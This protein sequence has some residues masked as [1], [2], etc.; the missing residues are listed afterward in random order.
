MLKKILF[1]ILG[2]WVFIF[3]IDF[4]CIKTID[5]PIFMIKKE[6]DNN[7]VTYYGLL[8][9]AIDYDKDIEIGTYFMK[10]DSNKVLSDSERFKQE[11]SSVSDSNVFVYKSI[12]DVIDILKNGTGV[13]YLGFPECKWCQA[14]VKYLD[15]V[16]SDIEINKIY[17]CNVLEDRQNNTESYKKLVEV[18]GDNLQYDD[19][20]KKRVYVPNVS[21]VV[22]GK[23]IGNDYETSKNTLGFS[24]PKEYWNDERVS[25]L[26][27]KL[28]KYMQEVYDASMLCTSCNE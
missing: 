20:G 12:D 1:I 25:I 16:S 4:I 7:I 6:N 18:L 26:K 17:Y 13:V 24:D 5:K 9:K 19:E 15:E 27:K 2:I 22:E 23:I 10:I 21:F 14:Y 8:Y 28:S 11:Y 3:L